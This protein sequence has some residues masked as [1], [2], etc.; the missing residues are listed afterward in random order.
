MPN[1]HPK[2]R[3]IAIHITYA[4]LSY[5]TL[6]QHLSN[7]LPNFSSFFFSFTCFRLLILPQI[8]NPNLYFSYLQLF[9]F[10]YF[11]TRQIFSHCKLTQAT[12][13]TH[14][15][16]PNTCLL[17]QSREV[18]SSGSCASKGHWILMAYVGCRVYISPTCE[19]SS[20]SVG[21]HRA[22]QDNAL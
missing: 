17:V 21:T 8:P 1:I 22:E 2:L 6:F 16:K 10:K 5:L 20:L 18:R 9:I 3:T 14:P 13:T 19:L 15:L 4:S 11:P 12:V 7:T